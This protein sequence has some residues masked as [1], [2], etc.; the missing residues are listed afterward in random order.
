MDG[1][2]I[3][4]PN[5]RYHQPKSKLHESN[6]ELTMALNN[7]ESIQH[8]PDINQSRDATNAQVFYAS[9]A[10]LHQKTETL[11]Q[12]ESYRSTTSGI[13]KSHLQKSQIGASEASL[14][15]STRLKDIL[16]HSKVRKQARLADGM[17]SSSMLADQFTTI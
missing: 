12:E 2:Q 9:N 6:A 3:V 16:R 8:F 13:G 10:N 4:D 5:N 7:D 14:N 15:Q 17:N 11:R 1:I